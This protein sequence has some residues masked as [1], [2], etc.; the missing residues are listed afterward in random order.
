MQ[1]DIDSLTQ[2]EQRLSER[3]ERGGFLLALSDAL[4][5]MTEPAA[6]META[7]RLLGERLRAERAYYVEL[8]D[9]GNIAR[10]GHDYRHA[11]LPS[12]AGDHPIQFMSWMLPL[13]Q[14]DEPLVVEDA[15]TDPR[16]TCV[17]R[18]AL[19]AARLIAFAS[20]P[21]VKAG[22]L[23]GT[24][25]VTESTPRAWTTAE[26][27]LVQETG[28]RVWEAVERARIQV[29]L[30]ESEE[31]FRGFAEAST[32]VLWIA[33]AQGEKVDYLSP[34]F[35]RVFGIPRE[36]VVTS[37]HCIASLIH[38]ED[39]AEFLSMRPRLLAGEMVVAHYRVL[40]PEGSVVHA[41]D[42][43]FLIRDQSGAIV[44]LAGVV[45]DVS[46]IEA[47]RVALEAEKDRFRMLAEGIPSLVW[48]ACAEGLW[49]WAS[50]QWLCFTGQTL[51]QSRN[52]GWLEAVHPDDRA[53]A[54]AAWYTA[55]SM[56]A[57]DAEFRIRRSNDGRYLWHR[58]RAAPVRDR[59]SRI[60]EWLGTTTDIQ[61]LKALQ[62][63]LL[64]AV[65]HDD[66][67]GLRSR[68]F[69]TNRLETLLRRQGNKEVLRCALLFLDLDRFKLVNDS[70][71]HITG[72][73]LLVEVGRRLKSCTRP[74]DTVARFGGDEFALLLED[75]DDLDTAV[76]VTQRV[77]VAMQQPV[78]LG[79]QDLFTT[80]SI[81][82]VQ[83][84]NGET[85][86]EEVLRD[87]D[88]AMYH[89]K[90]DGGGS[91]AVFSET[92]RQAAVEA[93]DLRTDLRNALVRGEFFLHYQPIYDVSA[94]IIVG[95]EALVRWQHPRRG[96]VP[97]SVFI[98]IAEE[99]GLIRDIGR[100]VLL[101][102]CIQ[103]RTWHES[104]P[105]H[106]LYLNV[107]TSAVELNNPTY[108]SDVW[109][110]LSIARF[111]PKS[112]QIEVTESVFL[113]QPDV[114]GEMLG[115]IRELGVRVAL[116]DFGTGYSSLSYLDRYQID[117]VKIDRSFIS[118]MLSRPKAGVV[119]RSIV[120]L[121]KAMGISVVAE[122]VENEA[123]LHALRI[124][125][126]DLL[127]GYLLGRPM[128]ASDIAALLA[129]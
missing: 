43:A 22:R 83:V 75:I 73:H 48:R 55:Q 9:G 122:G 61:D 47:A 97:P 124:A 128:P 112:L 120:S 42:T 20:T 58:T 111:D 10:V 66:L 56:G 94:G 109:N 88:V 106:K 40:R 93:L 129:S 78:R 104:V 65:L 119:V 5:S 59:Q 117:T 52:R 45:Q 107:N 68:A 15:Q 26:I 125:G 87:A 118:G 102:A 1:P 72:D 67:T 79:E 64:H 57:L 123:Q 2:A 13:L 62:E 63:R 70:L 100:W 76:A 90:R 18:P 39:R 3:E 53:G 99:S 33:D 17:G 116:D 34:A 115:Q 8:S 98:P 12:F 114:A 41:R 6:I 91:Y 126:C 86:A 80:C 46:D 44:Q 28:E 16:I 35:E 54:M 77:I 51:E 92:M 108:M 95:V 71:G 7:C 60:I 21:L 25:S 27:G 74:Q 81:G 105:T 49:S 121:G 101:N 113:H 32:D 85:T 84:T 103:V 89:A 69:L 82:L 37:R 110:A 30:R 127:Q 29:Q 96:L 24:F 23:V 14:A 36:A 31:R 50:P 4:R 19:I 38:S 11:G